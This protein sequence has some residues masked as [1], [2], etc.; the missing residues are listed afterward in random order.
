[1]DRTSEHM[2][3]VIEGML[4]RREHGV[5][6]GALS[7]TIERLFSGNSA[8][9]YFLL[10]VRGALAREWSNEELPPF[11]ADKLDQWEA[12]GYPHL[13]LFEIEAEK[14]KLRRLGYD[15]AALPQPKP[16]TP[17]DIEARKNDIF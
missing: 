12:E 15:P 1:M 11:M 5:L 9:A 6:I 8:I 3:A 16:P 10:D 7:L 14:E 2:K 4:E 13:L 17:R